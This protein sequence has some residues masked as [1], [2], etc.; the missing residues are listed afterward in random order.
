MS[1][2]KKANCSGCMKRTANLSSLKI[3]HTYL[4][5]HWQRPAVPIMVDNDNF[6]CY[7]DCQSFWI[8]PQKMLARSEPNEA[9]CNFARLSI[10]IE[11]FKNVRNARATSHRSFV[12]LA[13]QKQILNSMERSYESM[14]RDVRRSCVSPNI[15]SARE[16]ICSDGTSYSKHSGETKTTI[17]D[18]KV[19]FIAR[20][21]FL[22]MIKRKWILRKST[23]A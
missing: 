5:I 10:L 9:L 14:P 11:F 1:E 2:K 18:R 7:S 4:Q 23:W 3:S 20:C 6:Q 22:K 15:L 21:G 16:T 8:Q 19:L 13:H 17:S 12:G